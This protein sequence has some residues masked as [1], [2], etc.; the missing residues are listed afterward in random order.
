[1]DTIFNKRRQPTEWVKIFANDTTNK[2]SNSQ[3]RKA[4]DQT[5]SLVNSIKHLVSFRSYFKK[6]HR[7]K[8]YY[9]AHCMRPPSLRYQNERYHKK[10]NYKLRSL[11]NIDA[12]IKIKKNSPN[13][14]KPNPKNTLKGHTP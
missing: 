9:Q 14:S 13:I 7:N 5:A 3:Q 11:M 1:M 6:L 8:K 10:E 2:A 12:K 4:Q